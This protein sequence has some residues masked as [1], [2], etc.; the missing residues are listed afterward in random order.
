FPA[1]HLALEETR[2]GDGVVDEDESAT[3]FHVSLESGAGGVVPW[4]FI[5]EENGREF[6]QFRVRR[7]LCAVR[8][9]G[10]DL[11]WGLGEECGVGREERSGQ[12]GETTKRQDRGSGGMG[13][14]EALE[15][16]GHGSSTV[17]FSGV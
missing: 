3:V 10:D 8:D 5:G 17:G 9:L 14:A 11:G 6:L 12:Q 7:E 13:C 16:H 2:G 4:F 1:F 15:H